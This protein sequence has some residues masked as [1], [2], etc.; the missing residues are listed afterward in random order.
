MKSTFLLILM[1]VVISAL[2]FAC[3]NA[4]NTS[5]NMKN[6]QSGE[7]YCLKE[8]DNALS[9]EGKKICFEGVIAENVM[10][11]MIKMAPP[12]DGEEEDSR[13]VDPLDK[14]KF[15]QIVVYFLPS[16]VKFPKDEK[17][18]LKLYG[19]LES[20]TG[21]GKGGGVHKEHYIQLD[22]IELK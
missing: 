22:K 6:E 7:Y 21:A 14:Y 13:Y 2:L 9:F 4:K 11:H 19:T 17:A 5:S 1:I 18:V 3:G 15:G 12:T 8:G 16:K 10:Q 20:M